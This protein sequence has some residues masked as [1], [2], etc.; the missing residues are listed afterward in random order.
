MNLRVLYLILLTIVLA[1]CE[2]ISFITLEV[3]RPAEVR[4]PAGVSK[5]L[6]IDNSVGQPEDYGHE[7]FN[8]RKRLDNLKFDSEALKTTFVNALAAKL[9]ENKSLQ[10]EVRNVH[11]AKS[12]TNDNPVSSDFLKSIDSTHQADLVISVDKFLMESVFRASYIPSENLY[13][14][15]LDAYNRPVV[16]VYSLNNE[17]RTFVL[18]PQDTLFWEN[19]DYTLTNAVAR[20]PKPAMCMSDL[21]GYSAEKLYKRIFPNKEFVQRF[22]Y[23]TSNRNMLDAA[24]YAKQNRWAEASYIWDYMYQSIKTNRLKGFCAANLA[25]SCEIQ[26]QFDK[27]IEWAETAKSLLEKDEKANLQGETERV[28]AYLS[29]LKIRQKE[30]KIMEQSDY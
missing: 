9:K 4:L 10:V 8:I 12:F 22:I 2:S 11:P 14:L 20:F 25:L 19:Y 24:R 23:E 29:D 15:T 17:Q 6:V 3:Q 27:A 30:V 7:V 1:S 13:R 18:N 21:M 28:T 5:V 16:R 26:D